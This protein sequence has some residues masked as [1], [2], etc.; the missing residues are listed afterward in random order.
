LINGN[1]N[2]SQIKNCIDAAHHFHLSREE[3]MNIYPHQRSIIEDKWNI[4]CEEANLNE[5][6]RKLF[7]GRQFLNPFVFEGL[8]NN[9]STAD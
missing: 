3:A 7:W 4:T 6:D 9:D 8:E 5:I 1:I 2:L